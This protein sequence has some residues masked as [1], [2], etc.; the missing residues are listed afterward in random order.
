M[1]LLG[2]TPAV[3]ESRRIT[4]L[5]SIPL[6]CVKKLK[7][8]ERPRDRKNNTTERAWVGIQPATF[9]LIALNL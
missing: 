3:F 4:P 5:M 6:D 2:S 1:G 9:F 8:L 7:N